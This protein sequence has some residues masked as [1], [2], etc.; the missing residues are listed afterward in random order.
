MNI[1][2]Q[3]ETSHLIFVLDAT[4]HSPKMHRVRNQHS[5]QRVSA[6]TFTLIWKRASA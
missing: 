2:L 3:H 6:F 4:L 5:S 1:L